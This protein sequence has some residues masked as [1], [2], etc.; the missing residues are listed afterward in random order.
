[1]DLIKAFDYLL[2]S[3]S[4]GKVKHSKAH[5]KKITLWILQIYDYFVK[6]SASFFKEGT[7]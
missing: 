1:M 5:H 7:K 3:D 4:Y 6:L 2:S